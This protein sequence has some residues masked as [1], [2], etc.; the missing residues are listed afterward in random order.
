MADQNGG[1]VLLEA[2]HSQVKK[3]QTNS[4]DLSFNELMDMYE[5]GELIVNPDY[6]RAFRWSE[7]KESR[8]I[9]SLVLGMPIPPIFVIEQDDGKYELIDGLQRLS[10]YFH[11]RGKLTL[12]AFRQKDSQGRLLEAHRLRHRQGAQ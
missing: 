5:Q 7:G 12:D 4:L 9:E 2:V 11:F 1:A 3:V 10:S 6:Q 8:F